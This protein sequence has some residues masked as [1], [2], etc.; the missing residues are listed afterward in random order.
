VPRLQLLAAHQ[1]RLCR[2][3][4]NRVNFKAF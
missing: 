2:V 3:I 4:L 1:P